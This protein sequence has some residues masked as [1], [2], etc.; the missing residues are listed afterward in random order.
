MHQNQPCMPA[1][2]CL[3]L[4]TRFD[5]CVCVCV[6]VFFFFFF[7]VAV[8]SRTRDRAMTSE[9]PA[10]LFWIP[11]LGFALAESPESRGFFMVFYGVHDDELRD[12]ILSLMVFMMMICVTSFAN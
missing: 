3:A 4:R 5:K 11:Y 7:S 9:L 6:C 1:G 8:D 12:L 2:V 10:L